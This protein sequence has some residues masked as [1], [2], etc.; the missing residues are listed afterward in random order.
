MNRARPPD[1]PGGERYRARRA[2]AVNLSLRLCVTSLCADQ[3]DGEEAA[4][5]VV[6]GGSG[7]KATRTH[8]RLVPYIY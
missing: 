8:R 3:Y 2:P 1:N 5:A 7:A 6:R 4:G